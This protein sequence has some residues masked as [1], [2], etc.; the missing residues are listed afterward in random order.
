LPRRGGRVE[1]KI[2]KLRKS[3]YFPDFLEP[4]RTAEKAFGRHQGSLD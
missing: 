3:S 1:L 2:Q 4:R